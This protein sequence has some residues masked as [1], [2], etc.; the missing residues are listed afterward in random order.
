M[1]VLMKKYGR[2]PLL[3][4]MARNLRPKSGYVLVGYAQPSRFVGDV[5]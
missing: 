4:R 1:T 3:V 2:A 5:V